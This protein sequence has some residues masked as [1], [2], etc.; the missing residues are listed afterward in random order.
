[1]K[2][3]KWNPVL[4]LGLLMA[5]VLACNAT[6]A[7]ISSLKLSSDEE[8]K[9]ETKSF[10]PGDKVYAIAQISNNPGKVQT[11][12]RILYDDVE[13]ENSGVLVE[14]AE[15]TLEVDGSRPAIFWI[16]LPNRGFR[17]GRYK[18]EVS[19]LTESGEQKDQ[20]T[21]TFDVAGY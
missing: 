17:N 2:T 3:D 6:T 15:K 19:M 14:G 12:F 10:K 18:L 11:K 4:A 5:A 20:E 16:T 7:N 21:A 1:M 13:G 8:G 9:N